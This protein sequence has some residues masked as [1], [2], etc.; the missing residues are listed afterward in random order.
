MKREA[1]PAASPRA[2]GVLVLLVLGGLAVGGRVFKDHSRLKAELATLRVAAQPADATASAPATEEL[3]RISAEIENETALKRA[4]EAKA[5]EIGKSLPPMSDVEWR[6]LGRVEELGQQAGDFLRTFSDAIGRMKAGQPLDDGD[7]NTFMQRMMGWLKR[8]EAIGEMEDDAPEIARL[9]TATLGSRLK[10]DA[11][12]QARV[13]SQIEREFTL[14]REA[15]LTRPQRPDTERDDWYLRRRTALNE[16]TQRIEALIPAGQQ[17]EFAVGQSLHLG[18]GLRTKS[19]L[20]PDG[21]GSIS[22][23]L[24][25]PGL[26]PKF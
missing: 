19:E 24:D 12:T 4:A 7:G 9:H 18:T 6:S 16:A 23:A 20:G 13:Q 21:H 5:I 26:D 1:N 10:L 2:L 11:A 14:L 17:Q 22:M 8:M 25:L 3:A 15:G